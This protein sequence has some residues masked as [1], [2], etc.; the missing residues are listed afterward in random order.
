[1]IFFWIV[2]IHSPSVTVN[3]PHPSCSS[4]KMQLADKFLAVASRCAENVVVPENVECCGWAGDRDF[5]Y[6]E[7]EQLGPVGI[8]SGN[9]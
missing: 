7:L 4:T 5:F 9:P 8:E 1:M 6:P 2:C 3:D